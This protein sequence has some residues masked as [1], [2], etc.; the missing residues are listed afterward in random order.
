M[1]PTR[2]SFVQQYFELKQDDTSPAIVATIKDN[3]GRI[4][5]LSG[6]TVRFLMAKPGPGSPTKVAA[7]AALLDAPNGRVQYQWTTGDTDT[8]GDYI[9]EFEFT[10]A[11]GLIFSCPN[12]SWLDI[13]VLADLG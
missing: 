8:P 3:L 7:A 11:G 2:P 1:K 10:T 12:D 9:G 13:R 5:D 6:C 4:V